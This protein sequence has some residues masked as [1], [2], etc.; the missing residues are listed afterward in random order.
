MEAFETLTSFFMTPQC[1]EELFYK[2]NFFNI[3]CLKMI[4]SKGL[5]YGILAG[6]LLLRVP[7]IVKILKANSAEGLSVVS[8][9]L[10]LVAIFGVM[11]YGYMNKFSIAAYGDT[12]FLYA[13]G[14][15]I[16]AL[17][18]FYQRNMGLGAVLLP[19]I[20][21]ATVLMFVEMIPREVLISILKRVD[22]N[23]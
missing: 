4:L 13:Q 19:A 6:S 14:F 17:V 7:Q 23:V 18:L 21:A 8:E 2:F 20:L 16:I 10:Q 12:Y 9:L 11:A 15:V 22:I 5:G 1:H 3:V